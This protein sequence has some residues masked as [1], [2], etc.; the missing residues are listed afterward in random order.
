MFKEAHIIQQERIAY[1]VT[2]EEGVSRKGLK[3]DKGDGT[4]SILNIPPDLGVIRRR[5]SGIE[6][7]TE[8][9]IVS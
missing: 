2:G 3:G 4:G 8:G 7:R 6:S 5:T 9:Y 1:P